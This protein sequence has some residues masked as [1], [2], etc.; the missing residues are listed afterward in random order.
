[1]RKCEECGVGEEVEMLAY[2]DGHLICNDCNH[3]LERC[4]VNEDPDNNV[5]YL[6]TFSPYGD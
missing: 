4:W 5:H 6:D 2:R 3:V 1:M